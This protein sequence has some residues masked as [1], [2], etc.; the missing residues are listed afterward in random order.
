MGQEMRN[1]NISSVQRA[2]TVSNTGNIGIRA[3]PYGSLFVTK[4]GNFDGAAIF[5]GTSYN[6]HFCY[7]ADEHTYIRGGKAGSYVFLNDLPGSVVF[8]G[9]TAMVG[10]NSGNPT[11]PLEI[12]Q[13]N[14]KGL[15]LSDP[16]FNLNSWEYRV[17]YL[18]VAPDSDLRLYYNEI[19]RA[20]ISAL[21]GQYRYITSDRRIKSNIKPLP[22]LLEKMNLLNPVY[23]K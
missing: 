9:G 12:V 6:S 10:I 23:M 19:S 1:N 17:N 20:Y 22:S 8:G 14:N 4:A 18:Y 13:I 21:D 3:T 5:G 11:F 7:G 16:A 2:L 15:L